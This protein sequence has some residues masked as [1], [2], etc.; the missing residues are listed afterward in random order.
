MLRVVT[1]ATRDSSRPDRF[2]A[3]AHR[4]S[5]IGEMLQA[6]QGVPRKTA[7]SHKFPEA[8][9]INR[10]SKCKFIA[11]AWAALSQSHR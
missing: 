10:R 7:A 8:P 11:R 2:A 5:G 3:S 1:H 4:Y 9:A 6:L